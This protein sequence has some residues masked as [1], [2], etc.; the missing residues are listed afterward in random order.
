MTCL[1][2][3]PVHQL[4][5][6]FFTFSVIWDCKIKNLFESRVV[7]NLGLGGVR[8]VASAI[9]SHE[10]I[11]FIFSYVSVAERPQFGK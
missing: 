7:L 6:V 8:D 1:K 2:S 9:I 10:Q 5:V 3:L 4:N 11:H